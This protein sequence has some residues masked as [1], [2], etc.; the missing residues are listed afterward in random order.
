MV[1][2]LVRIVP[3]CLFIVDLP[4]ERYNAV[5]EVMSFFYLLL[6]IMIIRIV[7]CAIVGDFSI[8]LSHP[9]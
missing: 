7:I 3:R 1:R 9:L 6:L 2:P 4:Q 8:N 5:A